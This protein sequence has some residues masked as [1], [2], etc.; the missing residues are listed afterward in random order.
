MTGQYRYAGYEMHQLAQA[1]NIEIDMHLLDPYYV[2]YYDPAN[3]ESSFMGE[4]K[5]ISTRLARCAIREVRENIPEKKVQE[6][7]TRSTRDQLW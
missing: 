3:P 5:P 7:L 6:F 4:M 2:Q 1:L